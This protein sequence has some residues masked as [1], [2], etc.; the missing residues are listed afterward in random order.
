MWL[1]DA[2][3]QATQNVGL[4]GASPPRPTSMLEV[5]SG[6]RI[7][8]EIFIYFR[9]QS[10][11]CM[12]SW[13]GDCIF[14]MIRWRIKHFLSSCLVCSQTFCGLLFNRMLKSRQ[15]SIRKAHRHHAPLC[16]PSHTHTAHV[17]IYCHNQVSVNRW[18]LN[19]ACAAGNK[20]SLT[21]PVWLELLSVLLLLRTCS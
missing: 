19:N 20:C 6:D 9:P 17:F 2:E 3:A 5:N 10:S 16:F 13:I 7:V 8:W 18:S 12:S 15:L 1:F 21:E 11:L 4:P 14:Y